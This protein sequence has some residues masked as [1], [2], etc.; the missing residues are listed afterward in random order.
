[1][2]HAGKT[3]ADHF[4]AEAEGARHVLEIALTDAGWM[5]CKGPFDHGR[6]VPEEYR[7]KLR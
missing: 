3:A 5:F 1:M 6:V 4:H 7:A 2:H